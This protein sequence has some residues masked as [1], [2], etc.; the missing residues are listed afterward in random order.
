MLNMGNNSNS[1]GII[2][3]VA[4]KLFSERGYDAVSVNEIVQKAGV[5]KPT[6]YYF[7][8]SKEGVFRYILKEKYADFNNR[9]AK[10]TK[11][12]PHRDSYYEDVYPVLLKTVELYFEYVKENRAFYL[13]LLSFFFA[14]PTS[15]ASIVAMPYYKIHYQI[16]IQL[17]NE[18]AKVHSNLKGKEEQS[19]SS[20]LAVINSVIALWIHGVEE[21]SEERAASIVH[22]FMHGVF[23]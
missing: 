14:P 22:Q 1:K 2:L 20:F 12:E 9:L 4:I 17:F 8:E 11:Y 6:L 23:A 5:T 3:D 19:A 18:I 13:M 21:L 7:F 16:L 10:A 15:Q